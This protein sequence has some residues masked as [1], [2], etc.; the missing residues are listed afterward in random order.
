MRRVIALVLIALGVLWLA[1]GSVSFMRRETI[2][3]LGGVEVSREK[4]E[5]IP[6]SPIAGGI[7]LVSGIALLAVPVRS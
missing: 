7:L 2:V 4:R 1:Y 6:L 5:R 3:D